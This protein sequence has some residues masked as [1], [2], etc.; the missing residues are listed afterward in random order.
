MDP[1]PAEPGPATYQ[2]TRL[3][4]S[5]TLTAP[6]TSSVTTPKAETPPM[7]VEQVLEELEILLT[8]LE[9]EMKMKSGVENMMEVYIRDKKRTKDLEAQLGKSNKKIES[10]TKQIENLRKTSGAN[11]PEVANKL[12]EHRF[13]A[14]TGFSTSI[15]TSSSSNAR[16]NNK[17]KP[18]ANIAKMR[19][20]SY[21]D[22]IAY[23]EDGG[24]TDPNTILEQVDILV[25]ILR[26]TG[27]VT[28]HISR[29]AV[30][31]SLRLCVAD[32][33]APIRIAG[34]R[35]LRHFILSA[36]DVKRM[37]EMQIDIFIVIALVRD[38]QQDYER[39]QAVKLIRAFVDNEALSFVPQSVVRALVAIAEQT[40]DKLRNICLETLAE[41]SIFH[42]PLVVE[43]GGLRIMT[44]A[45]VDGQRNLVDV[46]VHSFIYMLDA[47]DTRCLL[48]PG[49]ELEMIIAPFLDSHRG[50]NYEDKLKNC[51]KVVTLLLKSWS[52]V[53]YMCA[54]QL[55]AARSVVQ[56]LSLPSEDSKK[57]LLDMFFDI[58]YLRL[59]KDYS[60]FLTGRQH[61]A[62]IGAS[63]T[64]ADNVTDGLGSS[65][66][67]NAFSRSA[68]GG[69]AILNGGFLA[70][71]VS[72]DTT[73]P[74][75]DNIHKN[76]RLNMIDHHLT[77]ILIIFVDAGILM[78]LVDMVKSDDIYISRK[79]TLL[80]GEI[81]QLSTKL[82][83]MSM[84]TQVQ[85]LP[86][87]FALASSFEDE[88]VRHNAT[89]ALS[90]IDRLSRIR[91]R[92]LSQASQ[93]NKIEREAS[94][95]RKQEKVHEVKV[96]MGINI[97]DIHFRQLIMDTQILN[98]KDNTKWNWDTILELLQ[99]PLRHPRRLEEAMRGNK[100]IKRL[101]AF[102]RPFSHRFSDVNAS[103][104]N[105]ARYVNTGCVL[106]TTLLANPDGVRYLSDN[107]VLIQLA[108][109]LRELDPLN[110]DPETEPIFST[111]RMEN[112]L[113][114]GYFTLLGTLSKYKE[115]V[116]I[117]EK[118]KIFN[119]FYQISELKA[120]DD[121]KIAIIT[122]MDYSLDGHPRVLLS[123]IMTS[124]YNP[125]R[126]FS[127]K[128]LGV[129]LHNSEK[130]YN[131]WIIRLLVT[132]LY[133][134]NLEV[135]QM[136]VS[137]LDEA[138]EILDNLELLVKC[139]PSLDH[140]GELGN[141]LL[142]RFLSSS[143]GFG[144]L[145][146]LDYVQK[147]MD[148]WFEVDNVYINL[149][150]LALVFILHG[151]Q[152][153][154]LHYVT[155]LEVSLHRAMIN[156]ANKGAVNPFEERVHSEHDHETKQ[157]GDGWTPPHFYG[158]LTR[159]E[160]GCMLLK[161]KG[162]FQLFVNFIR[163]YALDNHDPE[164]IL[165]LKATLWAVGNIG[166]TRNGLPFLEEEDIVKDIVNMADKCDVLSLKGT[167]YYVLGLIAKTEQG[168]EVLGELG[169]E[170]VVS[171]NGVV[172]GLCV[173]LNL[174]DFL[175]VSCL[176]IISNWDYHGELPPPPRVA[177]SVKDNETVIAILKNVG[178]MSNHIIANEASKNLARLRQRYPE[179]FSR[180]D[181]FYSVMQLL[182]SYHFRLVVRNYILDAFDIKF[183][184]EQLNDLD[185]A[186]TNSLVLSTGEQQKS[187]E[188]KHTE[189]PSQGAEKLVIQEVDIPKPKLQ[190]K[191]VVVGGFQDI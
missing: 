107:K 69:P 18:P 152:N 76:E 9:R 64:A 5:S 62:H 177:A 67:N 160:E 42:I 11:M 81:L 1:G 143:T 31:S 118:F 174:H 166:A 26:S 83:P 44:Q 184:M 34:F 109:A 181:V 102:Y 162:H 100:F 122:N 95:R 75:G 88:Q 39:E 168:V 189:S 156:T 71:A 99:G 140:L 12:K 155:Q 55:R 126:L 74:K 57:I 105:F 182:N 191:V 94:V 170:G 91:T 19:Q 103:K 60:S 154:N 16:A 141:P 85:S 17:S 186:H 159:T 149:D 56:A 58:F 4:T 14:P 115:G 128:Q 36:E 121:L 84:A 116:R 20:K 41:I 110:G 73:P 136:A 48:R 87:L 138:C 66:G 151:L 63:T 176:L 32:Q 183:D 125:I 147:E 3:S 129:V 40:G 120:R 104:A 53:F 52:G 65:N 123:K 10:L 133:D 82:L 90:H 43:T 21:Q 187:E 33:R 28:I 171:P 119:L 98:T 180:V 106:L 185:E 108:E 47:P 179:Y 37:M 92:Y 68:G 165:R 173:P 22:S 145:N 101:L 124:G 144:Y 59:P 137:L 2:G 23:P 161:E 114:C 139:R 150:Q 178:D 132:Q 111:E 29:D 97:D 25:R 134:P 49:V 163:G 113:S 169:W 117:M 130:E 61:V 15:S 8:Q 7:S 6:V 172:E 78:A 86:K 51:A 46:L 30:I 45:L 70:N 93:D 142:L 188:N 50:P 79:A 131:G 164:V 35:A 157:P 80:I 24:D 38:S 89:T 13:M 190:P 127:T 112:T 146:E 167:C 54:N 153:R 77:I 27:D 72:D 158:E 135:C 175:T 148:D 96:R